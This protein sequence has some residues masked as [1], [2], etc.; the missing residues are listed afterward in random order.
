MHDSQPAMQV[1]DILLVMK[2]SNYWN[3]HNDIS[4]TLGNMNEGKR[5]D[6][7]WGEEMFHRSKS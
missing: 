4:S 1:T 5:C 2:N 3:S 7:G 6:D